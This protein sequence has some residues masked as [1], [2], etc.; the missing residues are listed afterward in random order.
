M[1]VSCCYSKYGVCVPALLIGLKEHVVLGPS[2]MD[3]PSPILLLWPWFLAGL[4]VWLCTFEVIVSTA[5]ASGL[6]PWLIYG[7]S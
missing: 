4:W 3:A 7:L 2:C 6:N 1:T 5:L